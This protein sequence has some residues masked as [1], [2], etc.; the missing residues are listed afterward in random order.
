MGKSGWGRDEERGG[1]KWWQRLWRRREREK[2]WWSEKDG[3]ERNWEKTEGEW[4][5]RGMEEWRKIGI[6]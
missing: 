6:C 2:G 4:G 3:G 1:Q 5:E